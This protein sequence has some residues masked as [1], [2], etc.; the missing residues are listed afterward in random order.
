MRRTKIPL[1]WC[2]KCGSDKVIAIIYG[3]PL[4]N[5]E[6]PGKDLYGAE[7]KGHVELGGCCVDKD[8]PNFRCKACG[9]GFRRE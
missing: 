5:I 7:K 2:P 1:I 4:E 3:M 9:D 6:K 8:S